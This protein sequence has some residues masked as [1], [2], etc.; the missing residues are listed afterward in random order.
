MTILCVTRLGIQPVL[1]P[2]AAD[3]EPLAKL[4][5]GTV[6]AQELPQSDSMQGCNN[7]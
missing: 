7:K 1:R 4:Y 5:G 2:R 6:G 3:M